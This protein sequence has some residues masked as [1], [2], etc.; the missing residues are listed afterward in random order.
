VALTERGRPIEAFTA[1]YRAD[2]V[3]FALASRREASGNGAAATE[4][5]VSLVMR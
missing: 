4:R 2:R 1:I 5:E 3:R